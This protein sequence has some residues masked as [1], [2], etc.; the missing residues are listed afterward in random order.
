[1][2]ARFVSY[3]EI[4][5]K[6]L[7]ARYAF[8]AGRGRKSGAGSGLTARGQVGSLPYLASSC[9][10]PF[11]RSPGVRMRMTLPFSRETIC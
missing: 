6:G 7:V 10:I 11:A 9:S 1:M 5:L 8:G 4:G 2:L 3:A